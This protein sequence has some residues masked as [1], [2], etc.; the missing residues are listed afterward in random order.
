MHKVHALNA[1]KMSTFDNFNSVDNQVLRDQLRLKS[2]Y[3]FEM[4]FGYTRT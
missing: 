3:M 1:R 2:L 4:P